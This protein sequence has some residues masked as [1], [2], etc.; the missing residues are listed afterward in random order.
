MSAGLPPATIALNEALQRRAEAGPRQLECDSC[1]A[2]PKALAPLNA[3]PTGHALSRAALPGYRKVPRSAQAAVA[4]PKPAAARRAE[5]VGSEA[6]A[7]RPF[8]KANE[9][10]S[11]IFRKHPGGCPAAS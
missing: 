5:V 10:A 11:E 6:G 8:H 3:Q 9:R 2:L 7:R 1:A 4:G